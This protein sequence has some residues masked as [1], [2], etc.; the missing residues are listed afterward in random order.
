MQR[1]EGGRRV[2][3]PWLAS[4]LSAPAAFACSYWLVL[5]LQQEESPPPSLPSSTQS[6]PLWSNPPQIKLNSRGCLPSSSLGKPT[7]SDN[8]KTFLI[9]HNKAF[10]RTY[11]CDI[12][13]DFLQCSCYFWFS[14]CSQACLPV[15]S[16]SPSLKQ[17]SQALSGKQLLND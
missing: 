13:I 7:N 12:V 8:E 15:S 2:L 5:T 10:H 1:G 9:S 3:A 6:F 16:K 17:V 14:T 4:A 11:L